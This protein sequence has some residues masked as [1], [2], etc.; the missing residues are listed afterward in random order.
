MFSKHLQRNPNTELSMIEDAFIRDHVPAGAKTSK[1]IFVSCTRPEWCG[2]YVLRSNTGNQPY[3]ELPVFELN[4]NKSIVISLHVDRGTGRSA[5]ILVDHREQT[6]NNITPIIYWHPKSCS[7]IYHD[8]HITMNDMIGSLVGSAD[9]RY[10]S[11]TNMISV[12]VNMITPPNTNVLVEWT[13]MEN[14]LN[15]AIPCVV[16]HSKL[17]GNQQSESHTI[18][19]MDLK[20][21]SIWK[22][23][24]EE[25]VQKI[26]ILEKELQE[27]KLKL[28]SSEHSIGQ[29]LK[30]VGSNHVQRDVHRLQASHDLCRFPNGGELRSQYENFLKELEI[31]YPDIL[32]GIMELDQ[33]CSVEEG[34][35]RSLLQHVLKPI[36]EICLE[37]TVSCLKSK[38]SVLEEFVGGSVNIGVDDTKKYPNSGLLNTFWYVNM[39]KQVLSCMDSM[40]FPAC[41]IGS[42]DE[43]QSD[44]SGSPLSSVV[45]HVFNL[46]PIIAKLHSYLTEL[47]IGNEIQYD[48][49]T[50]LSLIQKFTEFCFY[51]QLSDPPCFLHPVPGDEISFSKRNCDSVRLLSIT[52][53]IEG[54]NC[55]ALFPGLF[56]HSPVSSSHPVAVVKIPITP[57]V[58]MLY[59]VCI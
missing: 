27:T 23:N 58:R 26:T 35:I 16:D 51:T 52:R 48:E 30:L 19:A 13:A 49:I 21:L 40:L 33:S 6:G 20:V 47:H 2:Q 36:F 29:M 56:F 44:V 54:G 38:I 59:L 37:L 18:Y 25:M 39:H 4:A 15:I 28:Q 14:G 8:R 42:S 31:L 24:T 12:S 55:V 1:D 5:W 57:K 34:A 17:L 7:I 46:H 11:S 41:R 22:S 43:F 32:R 3:Q 10:S 50:L 53:A 45:Q 9:W